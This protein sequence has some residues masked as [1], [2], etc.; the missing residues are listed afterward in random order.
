MKHD[1]QRDS[2]ASGAMDVLGWTG[3]YDSANVF[4]YQKGLLDEEVNQWEQGGS[5][6]MPKDVSQALGFFNDGFKSYS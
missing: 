2:M 1:F 5:K 4:D 6:E 3:L